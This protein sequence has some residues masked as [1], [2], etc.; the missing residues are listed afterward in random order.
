MEPE[1]ISA[2]KSVIL[3]PPATTPHQKIITVLGQPLATPVQK[4]SE[5]NETSSLPL[6]VDIPAPL[7]EDKMT[8]EQPPSPKKPIDPALQET[9]S[10]LLELIVSKPPLI[11][12]P[13]LDDTGKELTVKTGTR[14]ADSILQKFNSIKNNIDLAKST[15]TVNKVEPV[16]VVS[17]PGPSKE[18]SA[19]KEDLKEATKKPEEEKQQTEIVEE[20]PET[21]EPRRRRRVVSKAIIEESDTDSSD[22]EH[23]VIGSEEDEEDSRTNSSDNKPLIECKNTDSNLSCLQVSLLHKI[24]T[25]RTLIAQLFQKTVTTTDDSQSQP[26]VDEKRTFSFEDILPKDQPSEEPPVE[27]KIVEVKESETVKTEDQAKEEVKEEQDP[28]LHSL[29]L[30]EEEIPRS[31]AP[32]AELPCGSDA[33]SVSSVSFVFFR[34][35][36]FLVFVL[37]DKWIIKNQVDDKYDFETYSIS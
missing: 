9:D 20:K 29:L 35:V 37:M 28:N 22:S 32:V 25:F 21:I 24:V 15:S 14:I 18:V 5:N 10:S 13:K 2:P 6:A 17:E 33:P 3:S 31:P 19:V 4:E 16:E 12:N 1:Q 30:C 11:L 27:E 23:L 34:F 36:V 8:N 7:K 26:A